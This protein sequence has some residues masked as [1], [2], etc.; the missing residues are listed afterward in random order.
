MPEL[1]GIESWGQ[2][3][4]RLRGTSLRLGLLNRLGLVF[5]ALL[6]TALSSAVSSLVSTSSLTITLLLFE[7][8]LICTTLYSAELI[9]I[10]AR[11][12]LLSL[13]PFPDQRGGSPDLGKVQL[14]DIVF[15]AH[16]LGDSIHGGRELHHQDHSLEVFGDL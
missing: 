3:S 11:G 14:L 1:E 16:D 7:G 6:V 8:W 2:G 13:P 15:L 4:R 10:L 9:G 5:W 12:S